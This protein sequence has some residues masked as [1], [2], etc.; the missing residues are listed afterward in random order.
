VALGYEV[1]DEPFVE[2]TIP[3]RKMRKALAGGP[4]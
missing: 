4:R 1:F 3:H 2:V